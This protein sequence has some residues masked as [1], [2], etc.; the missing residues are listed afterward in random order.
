VVTDPGLSL[1]WVQRHLFRQTR[2]VT[3]RADVTVPTL[4][5]SCPSILLTPDGGRSW[6]PVILFMD[7]GGVRPAM[8][9]MAEH[10][11]ELGY[12]VLLPGMYYRHGVYEP[13][14]P[15]TAF[16]D[17]DELARLR[18]MIGGLTKAMAARDT[19]AFLEFLAGRPEVAG[20]KVGT[21][22]YCMGGGLSLTAAAHHP[23]RI[24][25][26]ASFHGG[27]LASDA[28]DSPHLV[29]RRITGRVVVAGAQDDASFPPEQAELLERAL[30]EG[31]VDHTLETYPARHGF[32]VPDNPTYDAPAASRHWQ[33]LE[34]LYGAMLVN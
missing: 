26:A 23:D 32:A 34:E 16:S 22:G 8:V 33:A 1:D 24:V 5:G 7:A 12:V 10:L 25:A 20:T 15:A 11:A 27:N 4:D 6:P 21:T 2:R 19:G 17:G 14:D 9:T 31:G 30:T 29:V 13:F 28:P 3:K 18:G